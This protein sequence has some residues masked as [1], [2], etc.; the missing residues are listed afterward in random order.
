M[1]VTAT[2]VDTLKKAL[3][4]A[5][6]GDLPDAMRKVEFGTMIT[7]TKIAFTN[8]A[9]GMAHDIT[10]AS[11]G[12]RRAILS[13][14]TLR[15]TAGAAG[16]NA[17]IVTDASGSA[18]AGSASSPGIALL[19][20][21]GKTLTFEANVTGFVLTYIPQSATDVTAKFTRA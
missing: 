21:D 8:M 2:S 1:A 11:H 19:S 15:V 14:T 9:S 7:P 3:N 16:A 18:S 17:R 12:S 10:D 13:V 20:D 4:D 5:E 6:P